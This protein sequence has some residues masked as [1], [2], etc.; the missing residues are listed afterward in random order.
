MPVWGENNSVSRPDRDSS[1]AHNRDEAMDLA[2][3]CGANQRNEPECMQHV[4]RYVAARLP[5]TNMLRTA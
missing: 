1:R 4:A 5:A 2:E 3:E